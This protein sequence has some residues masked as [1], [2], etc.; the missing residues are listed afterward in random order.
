M[1]FPNILY[2]HSH[3]TGRYVQPYGYAIPSPHIHQ[4]AE[5]GVLFRQAFSAAPT[6][7]PSRASLLTGQY[8]HS[9]GML[10][11]AHR[12]FALSDYGHL[13]IHTLHRAGYFSA[14]VGTQHIAQDRRVMGYQLLIPTASN[15]AANVAPA[16]VQFLQGAPPQPFF[17]SVG[18][19]ETHRPYPLASERQDPRYTRPPATLPDTPDIRQDM[20][21]FEASARLLDDAIGRVLR[22]LHASGLATQT[23]VVC[24]TDHGIAFPGMKCTL[25]DHGIGVMLILR[26]PE[27]FA[28]GIVT[29]ALVSQVDLFPTLCDWLNLSPP[30]WLEGKSLMPLLRGTAANVNEEIF[31]E[32]NYHAAYEPQRAVR[33]HRFKYIRRFDER[34]RPVL[35]NTDDSPSKD[36]WLAAGWRERPL[37]REQLYDLVFDL[38][39]RNSLVD[40]STATP[41]LAEMRDRLQRW[42][43]RTQDPLLIGDVPPPAGARVNDADGLSPSEAPQ[44]R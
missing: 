6:C 38:Q 7:S 3:D 32:V 30:R 28:G 13:I 22:G 19:E 11:L 39:E 33:T 27:P 41:A 2:I 35:P 20:S 24:T 42:M 44:T 9:N 17:L 29:D 23:L 15:R 12:G 34:T 26:G 21:N 18:F 8:P 1:T 36:V 40:D 10:G 4:L 5:E 16:A 14:E 43:E 31:G 37:A 25:T